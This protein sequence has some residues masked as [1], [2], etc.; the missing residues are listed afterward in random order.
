MSRKD[1]R[2]IAEVA[3]TLLAKHGT[4]LKDLA[5]DLCEPLLALRAT[6]SAHLT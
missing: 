4:R 1:F 5:A 2:L 6:S 3:K